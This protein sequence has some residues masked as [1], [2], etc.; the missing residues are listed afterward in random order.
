MAFRS[1]DIVFE[2]F[3]QSSSTVSKQEVDAATI[4]TTVQSIIAVPLFDATGESIGVFEILN[5]EK[6]HF[7]SP[8]TKT[9]LVKFAKYVSLL[10]YTNE[11]LKVLPA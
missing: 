3:A 6:G 2:P 9:I 7:S 10:F 8:S 5:C 11:L 1:K 4:G